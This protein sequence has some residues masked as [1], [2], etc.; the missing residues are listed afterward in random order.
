[1]Q[2]CNKD[3]SDLIRAV[4]PIHP[5][6]HHQN[7][8]T[9]Q[10]Q[11]SVQQAAEGRRNIG[12]QGPE[13]LTPRHESRR[14]FELGFLD[15]F[16]LEDMDFLIFIQSVDFLRLQVCQPF[17]SASFSRLLGRDIALKRCLRVFRTVASLLPGR[18][19]SLQGSET[20]HSNC[21]YACH[22]WST[23]SGAS[24]KNAFKL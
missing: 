16:G 9:T 6:P 8:D 21:S 14:V 19:E 12:Q 24:Q 10:A 5:L 1:M 4:D 17:S 13:V 23:A 11:P 20:R 7:G 18:P 2:Q 15:V 22:H 3:V